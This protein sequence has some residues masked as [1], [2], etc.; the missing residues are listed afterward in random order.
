MAGVGAESAP[1]SAITCEDQLEGKKTGHESCNKTTP[2][3]GA[4][5]H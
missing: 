5:Y 4:E 3:H 1:V 2:E